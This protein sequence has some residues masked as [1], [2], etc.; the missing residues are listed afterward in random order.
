MIAQR[1][2]ETIARAEGMGLLG[3]ARI[4]HLDLASFREVVGRIAEAGIG[5]E[6]ETALAA[7]EVGADDVDRLLRRLHDALEESP[8]P[9]YEWRSVLEIFG[10]DRLAELTATSPASVRRYASG[11]RETPDPVAAR[12]HFLASVVGDLAGA[13]NPFGIRRW[14][15]RPRTALD[16]R[17]PSALLTDDWSP[18]HP[19]PHRVRELAASLVASPAT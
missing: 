16:G 15:E 7:S 3:G 12:L 4:D 13:Y 14:F 9:R 6:I 11:E 8:A 18:D 17:A 10:H 5:R 2:A 1:V 19:G